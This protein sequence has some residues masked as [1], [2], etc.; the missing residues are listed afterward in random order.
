MHSPLAPS[1]V[2]TAQVFA[3]AGPAMVANLTTPLIGIVSTTAI[4]R[5][6]DATLLGGVALASVLF[7]CMFWLFGFLRMST[8][9][10]TAQ[11]LGAGE[12][13][14]LRAILARGLIVAALVGAV[15]IAL[16]IPLA[17]ILLGVMGGSDSVTHAAKTYFAIRIWSA[18]LALGNYVVLG[19]LVGQA[20]AKLALG[21]QITINLINV[22]A[23]VVLVLALDFGIAGAAIAALIAEAAGL[24][25]GLLI[26]RRLS[27]GQLAVSRAMLF[28]PAKL[29]PMLSVN[30]DIMIR[31][32]SLIAAFLFFTAQ[33]ARAGD[34]TL[35]ANAVL[36][37]FLLFGAFFLDGLA[38]AAEQLC[39]RAYGARDKAAFAG[40]VKLVVMWGFGFAL[41]VA[42]CFLLFGPAFVDMMTASA[43]VRRIARDYLPFVIFAPLLGVFAFA[44]DGIYIGA[45]WARD[46]RNLMVASLVIFLTAWFALRSFGNAGLW[47]ALLVH[48]AARG[49]LEALRYPALLRKSFD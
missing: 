40:A 23:T 6:G 22:A 24:T 18:P 17:T 29:M 15:L 35:A 11:S 33:G 37:N 5:L 43:E 27:K 41:A 39:G 21:T 9:A 34:V 2:T 8:V 25:L 14:E 13:S 36:N 19:W 3:I 49:G 48:Y 46:M 16:Q 44:F 1:K 31:T 30:R 10:F 28:D 47:G 38:N 45:T 32:A 7:D 20:R 26:A 4:G 42:A 12:T